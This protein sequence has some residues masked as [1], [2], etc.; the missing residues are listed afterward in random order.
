[1]SKRFPLEVVMELTRKQADAAAAALAGLRAREQ[2]ALQTL[3]MLENCRLEYHSRLAR[4]GQS[5]IAKV[6]WAN[7]QDFLGKLEL[8]IDQQ[9]EVLAQH[10]IQ[11]EAGLKEWQ[12]A[13]V[14]LKSFEVLF[15][16]H[17]RGEVVREARLEQRDQDDHSSARHRRRDDR[18]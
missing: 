9:N 11:T 1:M 2:G 6:Q 15:E 12:S 16:R 4:S 8:A 17:R 7:F 5:G 3:Q 18:S 14:K 10:R 13:Q